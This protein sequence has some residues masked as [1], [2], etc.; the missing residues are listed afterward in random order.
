MPKNITPHQITT[1][2]TKD[3]PDG[4]KYEYSIT[5]TPRENREDHLIKKEWLLNPKGQY[6]RTDGPAFIR[7]SYSIENGI[8]TR[9]SIDVE[10]FWNGQQYRRGGPAF[11]SIEKKGQHFH[12]TNIWYEDPCK[13]WIHRIDDGPAKTTR[14]YTKD[15]MSIGGPHDE[16]I[17][18][19]YKFGQMHR[20]KDRP[21]RVYRME[22]FAPRP[23]EERIV[24]S[25]VWYQRGDV[26]RDGDRPSFVS[27]SGRKEWQQRSKRHRIGKPAV[28]RH[29]GTPEWWLDDHF[30]NNEQEYNQGLWRYVEEQ[31]AEIYGI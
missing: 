3:L 20:D 27:N 19:W 30:F 15:P 4:G 6:H 13:E 26:H 1:T 21:A 7:K 22:H 28:I 18:L 17:R 2:I 9:M 29:E 31:Q 16:I 25:R 24:W 12:Y 11:I 23:H 14:A 5:R 10:W 8:V